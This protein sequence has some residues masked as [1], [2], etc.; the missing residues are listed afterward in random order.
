ME[1]EL[2][3]QDR[4]LSERAVED[5][6]LFVW[7]A[8]EH[9]AEHGHEHEQQGENRDEGVVGDQRGELPPLVV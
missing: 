7:I 2:V 6:L 4:E 9:E 1:L 8:L 3:A 5:F